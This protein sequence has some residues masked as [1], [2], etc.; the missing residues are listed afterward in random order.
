MTRRLLLVLAVA[1][2]SFGLAACGSPDSGQSPEAQSSEADQV[3]L[4]RLAP[5]EFATRMPGA[6]TVINVH[7]PYEGELENTTA[8]IPFDKIVGDPQVPADKSSN[9][10]LYCMTGRMSEEA[11]NALIGAGYTKVSHLEGGMKAWE[12]AGKTL[13]HEPQSGDAAGHGH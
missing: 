13:I 11:G 9:V 1:V 7:I 12:A 8:A 10:L 5:D 3:A 2:T 6:A 4:G